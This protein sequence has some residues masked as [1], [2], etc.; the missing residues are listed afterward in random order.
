MYPFAEQMIAYQ[1]DDRG[2]R[3]GG[4]VLE[5]KGDFCHKSARY[6]AAPYEGRPTTSKSAS[7]PNTAT[8]PFTMTSTR[9]PWPTTSHPY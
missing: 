8:T 2:K 5:V 7:I 3:I 9:M 1:A 6:L 4:L